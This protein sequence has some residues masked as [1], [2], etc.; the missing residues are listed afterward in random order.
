VVA[1]YP[2]STL[3]PLSRPSKVCILLR[4]SVPDNYSSAPVTIWPST[5][6]VSWGHY[7]ALPSPMSE[8]QTTVLVTLDRE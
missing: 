1:D 3:Q 6:A 4:M 8:K 5:S 7:F 2:V